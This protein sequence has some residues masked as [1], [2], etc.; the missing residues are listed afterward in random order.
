MNA[1]NVRTLIGMHCYMVHLWLGSAV[2][3]ACVV[4]GSVLLRCSVGRAMEGLYI[5]R[6]R[7]KLDD[8]ASTI[9]TISRRLEAL[10]NNFIGLQAVFEERLPVVQQWDGPQEG[11]TLNQ[12]I[13]KQKCC[14]T[15]LIQDLK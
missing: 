4:Q 14:H 8:H 9:E 12:T 6:G 15:I 3:G 7:E 5:Q 11:P 13:L 2:K 1:L 10:D